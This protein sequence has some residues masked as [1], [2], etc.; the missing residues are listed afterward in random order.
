VRVAEQL[1]AAKA[2]W[3]R[4]ATV[5]AEKARNAELARQ[6]AIDREAARQ[7]AIDRV[8]TSCPPGTNYVPYAGKCVDG[9]W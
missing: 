2:K 8:P 4:L 9:D 1:K 5:K 3:V 6:E 7:A